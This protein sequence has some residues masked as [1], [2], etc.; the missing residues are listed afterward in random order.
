M[1]ISKRTCILVQSVQCAPNTINNLNLYL[2]DAATQTH[3]RTQH[4]HLASDSLLLYAQI[5]MHRHTHIT[6]KHTTNTPIRFVYHSSSSHGCVLPLNVDRIKFIDEN[7]AWNCMFVYIYGCVR[8]LY[9][10]RCRCRC[11]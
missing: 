4:M 2:G 7:Y 5:Q 11:C 3:T 8:V 6:H 1:H 10:M 9:T